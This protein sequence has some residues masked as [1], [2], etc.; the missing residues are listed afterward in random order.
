M[1]VGFVG[2]GQMGIEIVK[3]LNMAGFDPY[4]VDRSGARS[5]ELSE[6]GIRSSTSTAEVSRSSD[7]VYICVLT[8]QQI[9]E[10]ALGEDGIISAMPEGGLIVV[11]TTCDPMTLDTLA[12]QAAGKGIRVVDAALSGGPLDIKA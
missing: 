10:V 11:H 4:V 6:A 12:E 3:R 1:R 2:T 7:V 8:D 9:R 5:A